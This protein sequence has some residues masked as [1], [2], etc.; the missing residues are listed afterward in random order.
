VNPVSSSIYVGTDVITFFA[1]T[2]S[3]VNDHDTSARASP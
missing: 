2:A 1:A 3:V